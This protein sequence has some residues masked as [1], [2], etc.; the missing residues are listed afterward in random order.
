MGGSICM[1]D[2]VRLTVDGETGT[3]GEEDNPFHNR[4]MP[5][6]HSNTTTNIP[7]RWRWGDSF[8]I[9]PSLLE[10]SMLIWVHE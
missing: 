9:N 2:V 6:Q 8:L 3:D 7:A 1:G 5:L 4:K 10:F